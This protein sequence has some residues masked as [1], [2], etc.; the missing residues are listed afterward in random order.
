M[1]ERRQLHRNSATVEQRERCA[2]L[3]N[4]CSKKPV[5]RH[6][7]EARFGIAVEAVAAAGT[8]LLAYVQLLAAC[9]RANDRRS[10]GFDQLGKG[11]AQVSGNRR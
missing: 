11:D 6:E 7:A 4:Q 10:G 9:P 5:Q 1:I 2:G 8:G 3:R